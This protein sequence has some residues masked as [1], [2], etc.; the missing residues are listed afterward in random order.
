MVAGIVVA[1]AQRAV[2]IEDEGPVAALGDGWRLFRGHVGA[3]IVAWLVNLALSIGAGVAVAV[4]VGVVFAAL[5]LLGLGLW[6]LLGTN[7]A[8]ILYAALA[9]AAIVAAALLVAAI[10]GISLAL[11]AALHHLVEAP[12]ERLLRGR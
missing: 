11:A 4:A 1:F 8:T 10:L 6:A 7:V 5:G 2:A 3:S 9:G 12:A